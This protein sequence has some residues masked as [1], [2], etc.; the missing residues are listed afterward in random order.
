MKATLAALLAVS[1]QEDSVSDAM[2]A[3]AC[4]RQ[5]SHVTD[6]CQQDG[7]SITLQDAVCIGQVCPAFQSVM[8]ALFGGVE[9]RPRGRRLLRWRRERARALRV[10]SCQ[11]TGGVE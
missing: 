1:L 5:R 4:D 9:T 2:A 6:M 11:W 7:R 10:R 8:R 3:A